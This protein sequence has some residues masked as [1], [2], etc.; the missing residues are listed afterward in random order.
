MTVITN[1]KNVDKLVQIFPYIKKVYVLSHYK[2]FTSNSPIEVHW[3]PLE[4]DNMD[5]NPE[6]LNEIQEVILEPG[7]KDALILLALSG[8]A[9]YFPVKF[10][11]ERDGDLYVNENAIKNVIGLHT[12]MTPFL[13]GLVKLGIKLLREEILDKNSSSGVII[14]RFYEDFDNLNKEWKELETTIDTLGKDFTKKKLE[15]YF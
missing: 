9:T 15:E 13:G 5:F 8:F 12:M 14:A 2:D 10:V 11:Y 7:Y 6:I 1:V 4:A 3:I